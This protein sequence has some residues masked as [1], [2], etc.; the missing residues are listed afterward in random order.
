MKELPIQ[1]IKR[2]RRKVRFLQEK[3]AVFREESGERGKN[4]E[5]L[6][7]I[8]EGCEDL[9]DETVYEKIA[10][11]LNGYTQRCEEKTAKDRRAALR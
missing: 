5:K 10:G 2:L 1:T 7:K 6:I 11:V 4:L 3:L 8:T 9:I